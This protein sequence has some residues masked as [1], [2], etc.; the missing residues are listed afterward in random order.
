MNAQPGLA[1][2][3]PLERYVF[4]ASFAQQRLWFLEQ[5][6]GTGA[7]WNVRL[8]VRL[9]GPLDGALLERALALVVARHESLRTT[10][11][12]RGGEIVQ[13]VA[14]S[15]HVPLDR[16]PLP[17]PADEERLRQLLG[18]LAGQAFDLREGP[19]LRAFLVEVS[20]TDHVLLL[21]AHLRKPPLRKVQ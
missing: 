13:F 17:P 8:P 15:V 21:L 1:D 4:P 3:L 9:A 16:V 20:A 14:S 18:W 12:M 6:E 7:A 5:L 10:F 11:G 2:E 19:L